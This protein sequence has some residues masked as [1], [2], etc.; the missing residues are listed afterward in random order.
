MAT[1]KEKTEKSIAEKIQLLKQL[2]DSYSTI[3]GLKALMED[4]PIEIQDIEDEIAK[5]E[6][7]IV[8]FEAKNKELTQECNVEKAN[9]EK[10]EG[11]VARYKEQLNGIKNNREYDNL[12]KEI[13]FQELEVELSNKN[14][15]EKKEA[16][17]ESK[18]KVLA[19]KDNLQER[20]EMLEERQASMAD[21]EKEAKA[22][23]VKLE[24]LVE[25]VETELDARLVNSFLRV[26][27]G[28]KNGLGLVRIDRDACGGCFNRIPAQNQMDIK[29]D[30][31]ILTCEYCGRI[32]VKADELDEE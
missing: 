13:E 18:K 27:N 15:N 21:R 8:E 23:I 17:Q 29:L 31:K 16:I 25:G 1:K 30:R 5:I 14:I 19:L 32:I 28:N 6:H 12:T 9:I 2:Q 11:L 20:K 7:R 24:K 10:A 4:L 3:D 26:R 22:K